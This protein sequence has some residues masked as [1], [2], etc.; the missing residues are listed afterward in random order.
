MA[1][2]SW[3]SKYSVGVQ[4]MDSQHTVLFG[5]LNDL[6]SAMMKGQAQSTTGPLLRKLAN[7]AHEHFAAEEAIMASTRYP[8]LAQHRIKHRDLSKQ[9]EEFAAR[10]DR[11]ESTLNLHLL[12]FL[13]DWLTNH[14]QKV[15]HGYSAWMNEHGVH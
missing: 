10:F 3:S 14:I 12:N 15:D 8:D 9:V 5:L 13:R 6:H 2:L 7:Y 4:S 11:G 1:L